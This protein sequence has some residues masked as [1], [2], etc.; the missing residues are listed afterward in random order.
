MNNLK[1]KIDHRGHD[2]TDF[3]EKNHYS[4]RSTAKM[5]KTCDTLSNVMH[6]ITNCIETKNWYL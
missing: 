2:L 3:H 5:K 1:I 6:T 4:N